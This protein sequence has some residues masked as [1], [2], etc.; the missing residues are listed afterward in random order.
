MPGPAAQPGFDELAYFAPIAPGPNAYSA[1]P[2]LNFPAPPVPAGEHPA[3][4]CRVARPTPGRLPASSHLQQ[5]SWLHAPSQQ[6]VPD[7]LSGLQLM[8][9]RLLRRTTVPRRLHPTAQLL[10]LTRAAW[11]SPSL[12]THRHQSLALLACTHLPTPLWAP[13]AQLRVPCLCTV[14]LCPR[15][16]W[17]LGCSDGGRAGCF[18][19]GGMAAELE[20]CPAF[21][22]QGS[23]SGSGAPVCSRDECSSLAHCTTQPR[24]HKHSSL[25]SHPSLPLPHGSAYTPN[26][27][28]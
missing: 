8:V 16:C 1:R 23:Q 17:E 9:P 6:H 21:L 24:Q 28:F 19:G 20:A 7:M 10:H 15:R 3:R 12:P 18:Q 11:P 13:M 22:S 14:S 26:A 27:R 2:T 4:L 25:P 5:S